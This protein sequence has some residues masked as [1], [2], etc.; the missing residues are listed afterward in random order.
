M[1]LEI[2]AGRNLVKEAVRGGGNHRPPAGFRIE[3]NKQAEDFV[4]DGPI[5]VHRRIPVGLAVIKRRH[6]THVELLELQIALPGN[7]AGVSRPPVAADV[8]FEKRIDGVECATRFAAAQDEIPARGPDNE[9][10][11]AER[12]GRKPGI[13]HSGGLRADQ[14]PRRAPL[15]LGGQRQL[16]PGD[17]LQEELEFP[18]GMSNRLG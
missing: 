14:D 2:A 4:A 13:G 11:R 7:G 3:G 5:A 10:F 1:A 15:A 12:L 17:L 8:V 16:S 18:G 6:V 9:S